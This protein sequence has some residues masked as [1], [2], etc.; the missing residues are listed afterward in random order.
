MRP[1]LCPELRITAREAAFHRELNRFG[2][3][4]DDGSKGPR[5]MPVGA[6][7]RIGA[8]LVAALAGAPP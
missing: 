1:T 6:S 7:A 3:L 5:L 4:F 2:F 8:A